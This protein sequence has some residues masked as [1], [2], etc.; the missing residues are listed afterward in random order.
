[1]SDA[2]PVL[3]LVD[4]MRE[5]YDPDTAVAAITG[6]SVLNLVP[7]GAQKLEKNLP[8]TTYVLIA[9][10]RIRGT[11]TRRLV[12]VQVEAW[13][14]E[15]ENTLTDLYSLMDRAIALFTGP[16]FDTKGVVAGV[17]PNDLLRDGF[18]DPEEGVRSLG[19]DFTIDLKVA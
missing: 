14:S 17:S 3:D 5:L 2:T 13:I 19:N 15:Q 11:G 16:N 1:M 4:A 9:A 6:R 10:P 7:R 18:R 8:I 12:L